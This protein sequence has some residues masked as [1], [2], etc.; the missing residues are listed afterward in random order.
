MA[1]RKKETVQDFDMDPLLPS[2]ALRN[3]IS[4]KLKCKTETQKKLI[5]SIKGNE[6]T[7]CAGAVFS[8]KWRKRQ[9]YRK[10][11]LRQHWPMAK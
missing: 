10:V 11:L 2:Q 5:E 4:V 9:A 7:I 8:V 1:R 3:K 6:I